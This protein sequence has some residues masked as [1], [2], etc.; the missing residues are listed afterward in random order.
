MPDRN[1][2]YS[3]IPLKLSYIMLYMLYNNDKVFFRRKTKLE[4][5]NLLP[6]LAEQN[7]IK[8]KRRWMCKVKKEKQ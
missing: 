8:T 4:E 7:D 1:P 6:S 3:L 5:Q 2:T